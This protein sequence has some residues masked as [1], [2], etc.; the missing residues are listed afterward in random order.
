MSILLID[1]YLDPKGGAKNFLPYLP[2]DT[3]VWHVSQ[4]CLKPQLRGI[5]GVVITGSAACVH[6]NKEWVFSLLSALKDFVE[7]D[8]PCFGI[9]FGHQALA[10]IAGAKVGVLSLPEVGWKTVKQ[11]KQNLLWSQVPQDMGVFLSHRDAIL[12]PGETLDVL[13]SSDECSVQAFQYK[14]KPVWGVQF[15]PE[16]IVEECMYLLEY[17][18]ELHPELNLDLE[19]EK[20]LLKSNS[21]LATTLFRN[22][23]NFVSTYK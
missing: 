17:R 18:R 23:L 6:D 5:S 12:D 8:I 19:K 13:A 11:T 1:C 4:H 21:I 22:F 7:Q 20:A 3:S 15:H 9:C 16:M 2:V 10:K 14:E